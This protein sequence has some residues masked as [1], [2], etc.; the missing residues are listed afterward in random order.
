MSII[1]EKASTTPRHSRQLLRILTITRLYSRWGCNGEAPCQVSGHT[2]EELLPV[3]FEPHQ[4]VLISPFRR[5]AKFSSNLIELLDPC[6]AFHALFKL[7]QSHILNRIILF[8]AAFFIVA[9]VSIFEFLHTIPKSYSIMKSASIIVYKPSKRNFRSLTSNGNPPFSRRFLLL[10]SEF[11]AC[12][13]RCLRGQWPWHPC[14]SLGNF[15]RSTAFI[16]T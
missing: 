10:P 15:H 3:S 2:I 14:F 6:A 5:S 1:S 7:V 16:D 9:S 12:F 8:I 4:L 13:F 11:C